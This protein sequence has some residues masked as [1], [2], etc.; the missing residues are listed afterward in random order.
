MKSSLE[1]PIIDSKTRIG[2]RQHL[3]K[4]PYQIKS[5]KDLIPHLNRNLKH[6]WLLPILAQVDRCL[7]GRWDYWARCQA[8]PAHA[9]TR[10]QME[11]MLALLENRKPER[12]P[13]WPPFRNTAM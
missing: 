11:P 2:V 10:W 13:A 7:W 4:E 12:L 3:R 9:W 1:I 8:V 6:G 5:K